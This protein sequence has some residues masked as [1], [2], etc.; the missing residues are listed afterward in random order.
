MAI[1]YEFRSAAD[2][3]PDRATKLVAACPGVER[4]EH[5]LSAPGINDITVVK[6]SALGRRL[7]REGLGF[8][9][10]VRIVIH[11]SKE[12]PE[13]GEDEVAR[14]LEQLLPQLPGDL[15]LLLNNEKVVALRKGG[16]VLLNRD[17]QFWRDRRA[18]VSA[19]AFLESIPD[20]T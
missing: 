6:E 18:F 4:S 20:L 14:L 10:N 12:D 13:V 17:L 7:I 8:E 1:E 9:S 2:L 5:G 15:A 3:D 11:V 19:T 16:K